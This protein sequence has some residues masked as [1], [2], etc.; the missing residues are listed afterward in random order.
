MNEFLKDFRLRTPQ[1]QKIGS[2]EIEISRPF[3][4]IIFGASGDL[5]KKKLIPSIYHLYLDG[6]LPENSFIYG[7]DRIEMNNTEYRN[8]IKEAVQSTSSKSFDES[9]WNRFS[10]KVYYTSFDF[11]SSDSY[12][13]A[14]ERT[15]P[16][17]EKKHETGGNRIFYLAIP[18]GVFENVIH[19]IGLTGLAKEDKGYAHLVIEKPFGHDFAS[20]QRLNRVVRQYFNE[21]QIFRIDHYVAKETVQNMLMFRFAN[22]I[23]EPL[24]NRRYIDHVQI[25]VAEDLGIAQRAG[26]YEKAGVIRDM[27]QSHLFQLL[28]VTAMEPPVAFQADR[29]RDEK[30][31]V[32]RSI[33]PFPLES[34]YEHVAVGQYGKGTIQGQPVVS[35]RKEA[36]VSPES[37]TFTYAAMKVYIDSWRWNGVPFYLRSGKRLPV[38]KTEIS[39]HFKQ[40]PHMMFSHVMEDQI[41]PN[42]L[43]F[44]LQP[45]E[46][47]SLVFQTK[48]PGTRVCLNPVRMDFSYLKDVSLDAYEWVLLDCILGD[49]M[50]FLRQEGVEETWA[51]LTPLIERLE[52]SI[53]N[54]TF[55][56]YDA[57]SSGPEESDRLI[58]RDGRRWRPMENAGELDR[59]EISRFR[60]HQQ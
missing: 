29:V 20:A 45:D 52:E 1:Y 40:V 19:N 4:L 23:F 3:G 41:E 55:P 33:R 56:N 43:V 5:A 10:E 31:K 26:Y 22:A 24:W 11:S 27:F 51:L 50:L 34:I 48:R 2:C 35:Y 14:L 36:G 13:S 37:V 47:I 58:E 42:I 8:L 60:G 53:P 46:G 7:A 32:L 39:I 25:T 28:A 57:G 16:D 6:L 49:Q 12:I 59:Q 17:L 30:I 38:R 44:R 18:P 9:S 15:L 21:R 54:D